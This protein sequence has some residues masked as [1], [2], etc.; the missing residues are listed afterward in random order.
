MKLLNKLT[1][2]FALTV[3]GFIAGA[4]LFFATHPEAANAAGALAAPPAVERAISR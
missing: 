1:N 3:Q 2:P 4:I